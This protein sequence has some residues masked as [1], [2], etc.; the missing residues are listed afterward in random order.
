MPF[1]R[2]G[3]FNFVKQSAFGT[4]G[5]TG[6]KSYPFDGMNINA[7]Y[8]RIIDDSARGSRDRRDSVAGHQLVQGTLDMPGIPNNLGWFLFGAMGGTVTSTTPATT[9]TFLLGDTLPAFTLQLDRVT[10][11]HSFINMVIDSLKLSCAVK[12]MLKLSVG[13][14]GQKE[15]TAPG[16]LTST[17]LTGSALTFTQ[18]SVKMAAAGG[19]RT[20]Y[21]YLKS[22]EI[23]LNNNVDKE[24]YVISAVTPGVVAF[25]DPGPRDISGSMELEFKSS[26]DYTAFQAGTFRDWEFILNGTTIPYLNIVV[27]NVLFRDFPINVPSSGK[28]TVKLNWDAF[29]KDCVNSAFATALISPTLGNADTSYT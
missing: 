6:W 22:W 19:S 4:P 16:A 8:N 2:T 20:A 3:K 28:F 9:H 23:N 29:L 24:G 17:F 1:G 27:R 21:E 13:W 12:G 26:A 15:D 14:F 7:I 11:Q 25:V 10:T 5:T 18:G